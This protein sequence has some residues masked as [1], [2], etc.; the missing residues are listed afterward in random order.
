MRCRRREGF[1]GVIVT[2]SGGDGHRARRLERA[3]RRLVARGRARRHCRC[4]A[5][6]TATSCSRMRSAARSATTR[7]GAKWARWRSHLHPQAQR[8]PA[9]RGPAG[10]IRRAG[11]APADACCGRRR[12]P[13]CSPTPT[14]TPATPSAGAR[15]AWGVQFHPEFSTGHMRGYIRA[16][17]D[18][19][20]RRAA[21]RQAARQR[22]PRGA[23][24]A[25]NPAPLRRA[26]TAAAPCSGI[27]I[28]SPGDHHG[29]SRVA[30]RPRPGLVQ[31]GH[32]P[33]RQEPACG[34]RRRAAAD[35]RAVHGG[36]AGGVGAGGHCWCRR[37]RRGQHARPARW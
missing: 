29:Y 24:G 18:A 31:A 5:S 15:R 14:T 11:H 28:A 4:S 19:L 25:E 37:C 30:G 8:R 12:A 27:L 23:A 34:V 36:D 26:R 10:R 21:L 1:A 2:G 35:P 3:Q 33:G 6:A 13:P 9:V 7:P 20:A 17:H 16:R 22:G 32:R